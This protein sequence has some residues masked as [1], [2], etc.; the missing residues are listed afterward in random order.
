MKRE[1]QR[2]QEHKQVIVMRKHSP[3]KRMKEKE[4]DKEEV[5]EKEVDPE[6]EE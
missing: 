4:E 5:Q 6:E 3:S 2:K 1:C